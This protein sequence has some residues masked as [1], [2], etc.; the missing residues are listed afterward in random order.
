LSLAGWRPAPIIAYF[1]RTPEGKHIL[2]K[3]PK[4]TGWWQGISSR[5]SMVEAEPHTV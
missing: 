2:A 3:L 5:P 4:L 1:A